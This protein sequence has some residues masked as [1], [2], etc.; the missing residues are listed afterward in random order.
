[1]KRFKKPVLT[2]AALAALAV[3]GSALSRAQ[4][5]K[6]V[7]QTKV[8]HQ[9]VEPS[10]PGDPTDGQDGERQDQGNDGEHQDQSAAQEGAETKGEDH[11]ADQG[12][13]V[14]EGPGEVGAHADD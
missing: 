9:R 3:G 6:T 2:A 7:T 5:A 12:P 1:M 10:K 11:G 13:S 8:H 4:V 14:E